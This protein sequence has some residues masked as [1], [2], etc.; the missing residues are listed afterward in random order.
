MLLHPRAKPS[1]DN[2]IPTLKVE[3]VVAET[4]TVMAIP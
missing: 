4:K 1:D 2:D 3:T